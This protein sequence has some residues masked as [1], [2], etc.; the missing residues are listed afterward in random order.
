MFRTEVVNIV[1]RK[2]DYLNLIEEI[3]FFRDSSKKN[4]LK[5]SCKENFYIYALNSLK[6]KR[7]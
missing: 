2:S 7:M 1:L 6:T 5:Y 3:S 4:K